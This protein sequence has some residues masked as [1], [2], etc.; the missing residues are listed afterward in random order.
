MNKE[1]FI[2]SSLKKI[3]QKKIIS[4]YYFKHYKFDNDIYQGCNNFLYFI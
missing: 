1:I 4:I 2:L 3:N